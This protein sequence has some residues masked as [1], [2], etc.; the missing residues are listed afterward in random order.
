MN[1]GDEHF[2]IR[3]LNT[4]QI[5]HNMLDLVSIA[6]RILLMLSTEVVTISLLSLEKV[7]M[8]YPTALKKYMVLKV[9][10]NTA[11]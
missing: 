6:V 11:A 9:L 3:I 7:L 8:L 5:V 2:D 1:F 4:D 10:A